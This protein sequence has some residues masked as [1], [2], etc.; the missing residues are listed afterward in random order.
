MRRLETKHELTDKA[1]LEEKTGDLEAMSE[2]IVNVVDQGS[3]NGYYEKKK[4]G[5][6]CVE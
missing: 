3:R 5:R 6:R 4:Q 2:E 1:Q